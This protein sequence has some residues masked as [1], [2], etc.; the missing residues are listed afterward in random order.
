MIKNYVIQQKK[1]QNIVNMLLFFEK[2]HHV[3]LNNDSDG[4]GV[5]FLRFLFLLIYVS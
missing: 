5:E 4:W 2:R 3:S 1:R